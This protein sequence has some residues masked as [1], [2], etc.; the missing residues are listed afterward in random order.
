[1]SESELVALVR[2]LEARILGV[3]TGEQDHW[4]AVRGGVLALHLEAW[5]NRIEELEISP[6]WLRDRVTRLLLRN[7][8]SF[9]DGQLAGHP[10]SVWTGTPRTDRRLRRDRRRSPRLPGRFDGR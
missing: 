5:G 2:D 7:S 6:D 9:G 3:P 8:S 4:A 1:M 10:A